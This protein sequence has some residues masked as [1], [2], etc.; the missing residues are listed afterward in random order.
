MGPCPSSARMPCHASTYALSPSKRSD[1]SS[2]TTIP[3]QNKSLSS[4]GL[5]NCPRHGFL[6]VVMVGQILHLAVQSPDSRMLSRKS[7]TPISD[8]K[9]S[10]QNSVRQSKVFRSSRSVVRIKKFVIRTPEA[11]F[12]DVVVWPWSAASFC[13]FD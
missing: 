10:S 5:G 9:K 12:G 11:K 1:P 6:E 7:H 3:L 2:P 13:E 4:W 8:T